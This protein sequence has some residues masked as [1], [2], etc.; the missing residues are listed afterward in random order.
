MAGLMVHWAQI[1]WDC[2]N[3]NQD[4]LS[5]KKTLKLKIS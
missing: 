1:G 3:N 4:K 2:T 5:S